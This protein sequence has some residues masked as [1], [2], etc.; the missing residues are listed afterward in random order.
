MNVHYRVGNY[1]SYLAA[2]VQAIESVVEF[3]TR[4]K[5]K[6]LTAFKEAQAKKGPPSEKVRSGPL[7]WEPTGEDRSYY[8]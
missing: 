8:E 6:V 3:K 7:P 5:E 4:V 1:D 2:V